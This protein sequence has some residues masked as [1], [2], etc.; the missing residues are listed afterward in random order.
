MRILLTIFLPLVLPT[1]LYLAWT[2]AA[3]R[4]EWTGNN[5]PV[6]PFPWLLFSG[7]VLVAATI[8]SFD[9]HYGRSQEGIYIAPHSEN[10][11]VVPGHI[12]PAPPSRP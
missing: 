4:F 12:V 1:V 10:G 9:V 8:L 5:L 7:V 3:R 2:G 6:F 11:Q